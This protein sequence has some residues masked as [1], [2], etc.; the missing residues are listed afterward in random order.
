MM[1]GWYLRDEELIYLIL[2]SFQE[3]CSGSSVVGITE[4][5]MSCSV[6]AGVAMELEPHNSIECRSD[7]PR[8]LSRL[9][10]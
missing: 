1:A 9:F 5:K 3:D 6:Q 10:R 4:G 8:I 2:S 7:G